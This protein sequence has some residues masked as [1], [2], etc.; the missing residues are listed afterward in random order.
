MPP[1]FP[2]AGR[3]DRDLVLLEL[4]K[5]HN[6]VSLWNGSSSALQMSMGATG[7]TEAASTPAVA[8]AD[9]DVPHQIAF[10]R[11]NVAAPKGDVL[12]FSS[13]FPLT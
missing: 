13:I 3:R 7:P 12:G 9:P 4:K 8:E 2:V 10:M 5:S 11:H 6:A 1:G